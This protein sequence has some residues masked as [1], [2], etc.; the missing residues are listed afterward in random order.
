MCLKCGSFSFANENIQDTLWR[1]LRYY[2][3]TLVRRMC[4]LVVNYAKVL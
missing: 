3:L 2:T 1:D 4:K